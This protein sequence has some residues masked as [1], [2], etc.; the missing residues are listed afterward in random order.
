MAGYS[1]GNNPVKGSEVLFNILAHAV[2]RQ[3]I[4]F[5]VTRKINESNELSVAFIYAPSNSVS[6]A[7]VFEAPNK[8]TIEI[9]MGQFQIEV[10]YTFSCK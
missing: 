6:N 3:R 10:S 5:G 7:N 8:Q 2:I 4:S 9:E 1:Y